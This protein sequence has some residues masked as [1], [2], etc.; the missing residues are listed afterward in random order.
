MLTGQLDH[1]L[2]QRG[3]GSVAHFDRQ[4]SARDHDAVAGQQNFQELRDGLC[5][6]D[7]GDQ[8]RLVVEGRCGHIAQ[9]ACHFHVGGVFGKAHR[10][11]VRLK[12]HGGAD[13]V[14]VFGR[15]RRRSQAATLF[16]DAFVV[17][18]LATELD[19]GVHL[20]TH[21][22][23]HRDHNQTV[24]EQKH[25]TGLHFLGQGFVVQTDSVD[26][27]EL[28][29]RCVEHKLLAVLQE[30]LAFGKLADANLGAL[31][32]GHD[33]HFTP[34][35]LGGF[36]HQA[37]AVDVVLCFAVAE[38]QSHHVHPGA[39][40]RLEHLRIAGGGAKGGNNFGGATGHAFVS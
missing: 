37:S 16:V 24:I 8:T 7:F 30:H 40:Q 34:C 3:H 18:Q 39:D 21:H 13:V 11:I 25:V 29:A 2:L 15:Q 5:A 10:H 27:T 6:L 12:T 26:I 23:V 33:G 35:A 14:H 36:A 19:G 31:Q 20:L 9:L 22:R 38:V 1:A 28:S 17:G 32:V 4:V